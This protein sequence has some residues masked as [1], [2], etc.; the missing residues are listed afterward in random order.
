MNSN[1]LGKLAFSLSETE[2]T[3][4]V[5][6]GSGI[7]SAAGIPN[8]W[9]IAMDLIRKMAISI[10]EEA[11]RRSRGLVSPEVWKIGELFGYR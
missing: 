5:L 11:L 3:Y 1:A 8:G 7:S 4:A 2:G 9:G 6:L 10:E